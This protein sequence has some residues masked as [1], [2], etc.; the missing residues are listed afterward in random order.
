MY[1]LR[2]VL[3]FNYCPGLQAVFIYLIKESFDFRKKNGPC[4][5][6]SP[7]CLAPHPS[8]FVTSH[9][10][11]FKIREHLKKKNPKPFESF[12]KLKNNG[13]VVFQVN[14][15]WKWFANHNIANL[16]TFYPISQQNLELGFVFW[17]RDH[18][19]SMTVI[20]F[21]IFSNKLFKSS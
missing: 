19:E 7:S 10:H 17:K 11:K 6:N 2:Y 9:S 5:P 16:K 4:W 15:D 14:I 3:I 8:F 12:W 20:F 1:L 18:S 21:F 13:F